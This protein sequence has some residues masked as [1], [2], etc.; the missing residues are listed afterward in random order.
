MSL[1]GNMIATSFAGNHSIVNYDIFVSVFAMLSLFYLIP[2]TIKAELAFY[3]II[4]IVLDAL[5]TLLFLIG[6]VATANYLGI[7]RCSNDVCSVHPL[8]IE[9]YSY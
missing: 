5:N 1:V 4:M 7:H 8:A 2:A 9:V 3:P 6:G